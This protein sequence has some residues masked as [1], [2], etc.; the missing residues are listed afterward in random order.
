[1]KFIADTDAAARLAAKR[2]GDELKQS[3]IV[4]NKAGANGLLAIQTLKQRKPNGYTLMMTTGFDDN[5]A[6]GQGEGSL[7]H[8]GR[9]VAS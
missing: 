3:F 7:R 9:S 5:Y 8:V 2:L 6:C 4:D 1:M